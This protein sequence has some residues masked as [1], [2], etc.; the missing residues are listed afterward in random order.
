MSA[1]SVD[2]LAAQA[3]AGQSSPGTG[4]RPFMPGQHREFFSLLAYL[5]IG[6]A[7]EEGW[8]VASVLWGSPGFVTSPDPTTLRIGALPASDDPLAQGVRREAQIGLLGL[9]LS[10]RR[11]NRANGRIV[12][13]DRDGITVGISQSFGNCPQY[14]QTRFASSRPA[15]PEPARALGHLDEEARRLIATTDTF[16][17]ASRSR[18]EIAN[19][20]F[21]ASHRGGRPG[22]IGI[23]Q[24]TFTI[25]EF[26]GNRFFNTLG[27]LLGDS[28]AGLLFVDFSNGDLLQLQGRVTI[29]WKRGE[30]APAGT[31]RVWRCHIGRG[32]RRARA[33]PFD[34]EFGESAP[35]TLSTGIWKTTVS[36]AS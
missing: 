29:D 12:G 28:R 27:N 16:I 18:A 17:V 31:L 7:D 9:D 32:W 3:L 24:D 15:N 19:G 23:E 22:F 33:L 8:P 10:N 6:G 25:P 35:T 14:I 13:M 30:G 34:W 20:G 21:D 26:A 36:T 1:F 5:F 11:R 4:I 2:E